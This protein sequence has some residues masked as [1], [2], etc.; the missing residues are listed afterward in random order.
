MSY[1]KIIALNPHANSERSI[2]LRQQY[3]LK[4]LNWF[5]AKKRIISID[6]TWLG[7]TDFRHHKWCKAGVKNSVSKALMTNRI[8]MIVAVDNTGEVYLSLSQ[9]NSNKLVMVA[10]LRELVSKLN[11]EGRA[12]R[13]KTVIVHDGAKYFNN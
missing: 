7:M 13:S 8:S 4:L 1:K 9:S 3:S 5:Q 12:W 2:V 6:E 10:F 11:T